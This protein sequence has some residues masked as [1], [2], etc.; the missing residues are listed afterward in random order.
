MPYL[1]SSLSSIS[2]SLPRTWEWAG[3]DLAVSCLSPACYLLPSCVA[4][5]FLSSLP[6]YS[7]C[8]TFS[9]ALPQPSL[10]LL[11]TLPST[12]LPSFLTTHSYLPFSMSPSLPSTTMPCACPFH[13]PALPFFSPF[14]PAL[15]FFLSACCT[16]PTSMPLHFPCPL[17]W[18][19]FSCPS[20]LLPSILLRS[21]YHSETGQTVVVIDSGL[22]QARQVLHVDYLPVIV[23]SGG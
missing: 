11:P 17:H 22:G 21:L 15:S 13:I 18:H 14:L 6:F 20:Y 5:L 7:N 9:L 23:N 3:W 1:L 8:S 16:R 4:F 2:P 10:S 12:R 19:A